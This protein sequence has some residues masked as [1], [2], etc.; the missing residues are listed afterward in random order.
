MQKSFLQICLFIFPVFQIDFDET[1]LTKLGCS[2][3]Q[4]NVIFV[5][6]FLSNSR[7]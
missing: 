2:Y 7:L 3:L 4:K 5:Y 1:E 6:I